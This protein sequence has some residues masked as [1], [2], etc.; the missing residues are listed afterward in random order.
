MQRVAACRWGAASSQLLRVASAGRLQPAFAR[1]PVMAAAASAEAESASASAD[2]DG[3]ALAEPAFTAPA[4]VLDIGERAASPT[5]LQLHKLALHNS[6]SFQARVPSLCPTDESQ[7]G[8]QLDAKL[9]KLQQLFSDLDVPAA[10]E[11][12]TSPPSHYRMRAEF[13]LDQRDGDLNYVMFSKSPEEASGDGGDAEGDGANRGG[14][15]STST[16][17]KTGK[18]AGKRHGP[19][20]VRITSFPVAS[21]QVRTLRGPLRVAA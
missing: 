2:G 15:A 16:P 17:A 11:V 4:A 6:T 7:Y 19:Q 9:K 14:K 1:R 21:H 20:R 12:F 13:A 5:P 3:M 18:D 8:A 10:P